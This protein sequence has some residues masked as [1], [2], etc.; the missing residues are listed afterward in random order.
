MIPNL[1]NYPKV[2]AYMEQE[3]E[4]QEISMKLSNK[5]NVAVDEIYSNIAKYSHATWGQVVC[6]IDDDFIRVS[7]MDNGIPYNP[8]EAREPDLTLS[9]DERDVGGLGILLTRKLMDNITYNHENGCNHL[10][11]SLSRSK[12]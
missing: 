8:L 4:K 10:E 11:I 9:A 2:V 7:F 1:E 3:L 12:G 6:F 5:I